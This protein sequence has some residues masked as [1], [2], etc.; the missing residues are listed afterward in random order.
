MRDHHP[1]DV[2][3]MC[4]EATQRPRRPRSLPSPLRTWYAGKLWWLM[5]SL[6]HRLSWP[7]GTQSEVA[8]PGA[9]GDAGGSYARGTLQYL[10]LRRVITKYSLEALPLLNISFLLNFQTR[11]F[12]TY[13][14]KFRKIEA[15]IVQNKLSKLGR[16]LQCLPLLGLCPPSHPCL[17]W[18]KTVED[19][20]T[21][22]SIPW[23]FCFVLFLTRL[24]QSYP[25]DTVSF[26][27]QLYTTRK[28][29]FMPFVCISQTMR[30]WLLV[31]LYNYTQ[32]CNDIRYSLL[33]I[34]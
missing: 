18:W 28:L 17:V 14:R 24:Q 4:H 22:L 7:R 25:I 6:W 10:L 8:L 19:S 15:K 21:H 1:A 27:H 20:H 12:L 32:S 2:P 23:L 5:W 9:T 26:K 33:V 11:Y 31:A 3:S 29:T 13:L 30:W 34:I 16:T